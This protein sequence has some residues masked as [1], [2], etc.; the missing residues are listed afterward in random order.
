MDLVARDKQ[1]LESYGALL[2]F[3]APA[4]S[5]ASTATAEGNVQLSYFDNKGCMRFTNYD[6]AADSVN[7][8]FEQWLPDN[9][10]TCAH[11][12]DVNDVC[13]VKGKSVPLE[14]NQ[15]T[16]DTWF[17]YPLAYQ[18]DGNPYPLSKI[19][20]SKNGQDAA[21]A[22]AEN[23]W[24]G[25]LVGNYFHDAGFDLQKN[26]A[27]GWHHVAASGTAGATQFYVNGEP[28]GHS[29]A[30]IQSNARHA[31]RF[32]GSKDYLTVPAIEHNLSKGFTLTCWT[33]FEDFK[34]WSRI[35]DFSK[36]GATSD[37]ILL[38][39]EGATNNLCL[40]IYKGTKKE[41]L[42]AKRVL[43]KN[44]WMHIA[45]SIDSSGM[46]S[47]YVNGQEVAYGTVNLP[48]HV[49][50]SK[51]YIGKS[52][53]TGN[54]LFK[55][56]LSNM[57][58]WSNAMSQTEIQTNMYA[59]VTG[60]ENGLL[61]HW[62]MNT[63]EIGGVDVVG[64]SVETA[65]LNA[66][67]TGAPVSSLL[68]IQTSEP[69]VAIG[70]A[71]AGG[72]PSGKLSELRVWSA[73]LSEEE[74]RVNSKVRA[75]GNEPDLEAYYPLNDAGSDTGKASDLSAFDQ[76]PGIYKGITTVPGTAP[77]GQA[78]NKVLSFDGKSGYLKIRGIDLRKKSFTIEF[79]ALRSYADTNDFVVSQGGKGTNKGLHYG[80]RSTNI[81][82]QAF[83]GNDYN[84][85]EEF[86]APVWNH[87]SFVYDYARKTQTIYVNGNKIGSRK[88]NVPKSTKKKGLFG[89]S[90][91]SAVPYAGKGD[92]YIG[93]LA[94]SEDYF[95]GQLSDLRIWKTARTGQEVHATFKQRLTGTEKNL[96][97]YWQM[98]RVE[99]GKI[100]NL[101]A[102]G[103]DAEVY[104]ANVLMTNSLPL[105]PGTSLITAEYS[106]VGTS[107]DDPAKKR[108]IL[109][110]F[111]AFADHGGKV[112]L[113]P[114]K[115]IEELVLKWIGNAQ[116]QPTL[117]G[118]I[119]GAPPV[120]SENL[121]VNYDYDGATSVQLTQSEDT[122]YSW[123]RTKDSSKGVDLN[124]F[125][126]AGWGAEGGFGVVSKISE[127]KAGFRGMM[128]LRDGKTSSSTIRA[129]STSVMSDK[130][131]LRGSYETSP[132]FDH[133]GNRY[134]PKNVGYALVVSG[135]ADVFITQ[136][137]RTGRMI[138]YEVLPVKD[139]PMDIN[140]ITFM[141]NP[142]YTQNGSLDGLVGSQAADERFYGDVPEMRAQYGSLYPASYYR[143]KEAY[144]LKAQID[145]WDKERESYFV[146]YDSTQ[147]SAA[148]LEDQTADESEYDSYG[149]V[150]LNADSEGEV[151]EDGEQRSEQEIRDEFKA[152]SAS[153]KKKSKA[154]AK[155]RK[156]EI[157]GKIDDQ[158]KQVEAATAFDAWQKRMENLQ[159]RA[160]KRNIVNTYVWDADGG[161]RSEEQSFANTVEHTIGGSFNLTGSLG[162]DTDVMVTGF[163]FELSAL[164][165]MEMT[166]TMSKTK[167]VT[168]GFD[169]NIR[170]DGVEQKGVTN[171]KD[172]PILPGEKV[173]RYRFM[174]F[175]L[176]GNTDH[177]N[178][179]FN[180]VI[181]PEWLLS[182]DEEARALRQVQAGRAN[183]CWRVLHRVTYVERPALMGFGQ[184]LRQVSNAEKAS[185][186]VLNYFD[187]LEQDNDALRADL[188]DLKS[189]LSS[190]TAKM[191]SLLKNNND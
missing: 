126:G 169:L 176:E 15:W 31:L 168:T 129:N 53:W 88:V 73:A 144:D 99:D 113:Y 101:C 40:A 41:S 72:A 58:L 5:I 59:F 71:P 87:F 149:S 157:Q 83:Y 182:N 174:S 107:P 76:K 138:G 30:D 137:K 118:Y 108:A 45:A 155:K 65:S 63:K 147:T 153:E 79:W 128:N 143:L 156:K 26:L 85:K 51:N 150:S 152:S 2:G 50:R 28:V 140:T 82:T 177:F 34:S 97:G 74:M 27:E 92:V 94:W 89:S 56:S 130:L 145:R 77:I 102:K 39:N 18:T 133:L 22:I 131:E 159:I 38:A 32:N 70:N 165:A 21:I 154:E 189:Q 35:I 146:N 181:D 158:E 191:D 57:Q 117:L 105:V 47:L 148:A 123:M 170:L 24:L 8:T 120:P 95:E 111:Y 184:D 179:F 9:A 162:L 49:K 29:I 68:D 132:Q 42:I 86:K 7:P 172:Y 48:N 112:G 84:T 185:G 60:E 175:Y 37:N 122:S 178:D 69:I 186:E 14:K 67:I 116:F 33:Y 17:Y 23:T 136:M 12:R 134:L 13:L 139:I 115:R 46:A 20:S 171:A 161:I 81:L 19:V 93:K 96:L 43:Q 173:D 80:F 119:E 167:S 16:V 90:S 78:G 190:L 109:R 180:Y 160:A 6:A 36:G 164:Y 124:M 104:S 166:Q 163:K 121:T 91:S 188:G 4:H 106:T 127:G 64:D 100:K 75:T 151:G 10:K 141:I 142:A 135:M 44:T 110:R 3:A 187:A 114:G 25:T 52:N 66:K 98:D 62:A 61:N 183:K 103:K 1:G 125:L 54:G 11:F 55:G